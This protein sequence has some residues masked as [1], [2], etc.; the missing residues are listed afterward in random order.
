MNT[1]IKIGAKIFEK[2]ASLT[3]I[4][5]DKFNGLVG[6]M[7]GVWPNDSSVVVWIDSPLNA[8]ADDMTFKYHETK[9]F[10]IAF[11]KAKELRQLTANLHNTQ[12]AS[13]AADT[14]KKFRE[15]VLADSPPHEGAMKQEPEGWYVCT[16]TGESWYCYD[17]FGG[18]S[19]LEGSY[20]CYAYY[21]PATD[22][23]INSHLTVVAERKQIKRR[24]SELVKVMKSSEVVDKA[25]QYET[26]WSHPQPSAT[27]QEIGITTNGDAVLH[28]GQKPY[29]IDVMEAS[30]CRVLTGGADVAEELS[31]LLNENGI[32][33]I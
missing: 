17:N 22:E 11:E 21:V 32:K 24:I 2:G 5:D 1:A 3:I 12:Q 14:R 23:Q 7:V 31:N 26:T 16:G 25:P 27:I 8:D 6:E 33:L 13:K 29:L 19:S 28:T 15:M 10:V 18:D 30:T 20:V 4:S 9:E